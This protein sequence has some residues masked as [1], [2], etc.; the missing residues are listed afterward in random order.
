MCMKFSL[1]VY[2]QAQVGQG[3]CTLVKHSLACLASL[4]FQRSQSGKLPPWTQLVYD[5]LHAK[6][7]LS[8]SA[9]HACYLQAVEEIL[10]E[11]AQC[12]QPSRQS[13]ERCDPDALISAVGKAFASAVPTLGP[14]ITSLRYVVLQISIVNWICCLDILAIPSRQLIFTQ[15]SRVQTSCIKPTHSSRRTRRNWEAVRSFVHMS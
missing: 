12:Y 11:Y 10:I 5:E 1:G 13:V 6:Q 8:Y 2:Q 9:K 3:A 4:L 7:G 15:K 14:L